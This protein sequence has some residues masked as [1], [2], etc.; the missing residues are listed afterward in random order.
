MKKTARV[1]ARVGAGTLVLVLAAL[2]LLPAI[3]NLSGKQLLVVLSGSMEPMFSAGDA[4]VVSKPTEE[5]LVPGAVISYRA[6]GKEQLT[7]HRVVALREVGGE[8]YVQ[9]KGDANA[10]ADPD[11][12]PVA[13]VVGVMGA[14]IPHAGTALTW[15][16]DPELRLVSFGVPLLL[17]AAGALKDLRGARAPAPGE[18]SERRRDGGRPSGRAW[19]RVGFAVIVLVAAV[20]AGTALTGAVLVDTAPVGENTFST[21]PAFL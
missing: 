9:T 4:V 2:V 14:V 16:S 13:N 10:E 15:V 7:T 6:V 3:V 8:A 5:T 11:F 21:A 20:G 19:R 17:A 12:T 1:V 18:E